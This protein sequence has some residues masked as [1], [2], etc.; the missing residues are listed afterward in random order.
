MKT[1]DEVIKAMLI[2]KNEDIDRTC[3]GCPMPDTEMCINELMTDALHYLEE[4][5]DECNNIVN[6]HDDYIHLRNEMRNIYDV[7]SQKLRN[8]SQITCPKCHSEFVILDDPDGDHAQLLKCQAL[9]QDFYR[10][11]PLTWDEL[12]LMEGKPV[13]IEDGLENGEW[14]IIECFTESGR[15]IAHDRYADDTVFKA[16]DM[17]NM[18][19]AYRKERL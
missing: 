17:G 1:L 6:V 16:I 5:R 2:C 10:N 4:Y 19:Q 11:D 3:E 8:T 7:T 14:Y 13:W 12:K 15:F 18:W 9:L